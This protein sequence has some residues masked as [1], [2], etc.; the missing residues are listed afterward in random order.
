MRVEVGQSRSGNGTLEESGPAPMGTREAL[1]LELQVGTLPNERRG[2]QRVVA[3]RSAK[4]AVLEG[5]RA[6]FEAC[7]AKATVGQYRPM[8]PA[9]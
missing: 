8:T 3:P 7:L 5:L 6:G 4:E 1:G 2:E 9:T